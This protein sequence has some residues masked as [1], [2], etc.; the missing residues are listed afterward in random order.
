MTLSLGAIL[1]FTELRNPRSS[2]VLA[3]WQYTLI[4]VSY[5]LSII[6]A[7]GLRYP[8]AI[9]PLAYAQ[10]ILDTLI[11]S[12]LVTMTG[13]IESVFTFVYV[14]TVLGG[15]MTLYRRGAVVAV[16]AYFVSLGGIV[17]LQ[18]GKQLPV[19]ITF[20]FGRAMVSFS[21][22]SVGMALVAVLSS[23]LAEK[24]R[25]AGR[26]LAEKQID[27]EQLEELHAAILRSLP[28]GLMTIDGE[29]RVRYANEAAIAILRL[30]M[31]GAIGR[32]LAEVVAPMA[33]QWSEHRPRVSL[34]FDAA[35]ERF[36]SSFTRGD[37]KTIRIG[38]SFAP[39]GGEPGLGS[40]AVFQDVTEIVRLK[41]AVERAERLAT[42]GRL[43]AGLAHEVRNPLASM[44]ASIEVLRQ[45][46]N[47]PDP[48]KRLMS[49]VVKEADRLN[50]LIT[51]FLAFAR[52]REPERRRTDL[53][54][55]VAGVV[56]VL[57]HD[58]LFQPCKL[59]LALE[60]GLFAA[61]DADQIRQVVWN[62]A[63]N[64]AE[65]MRT[66]SNAVLS[67]QTK[68]RGDRVELIV[69]DTGPGIATEDLPRLFVPFYTT[70]EGGSGLG[71]AITHAIVEAHG[72]R[73]LFESKPGVG[74]EVTV[75]LPADVV[76]LPLPPP[77]R[78][79]AGNTIEPQL[80]PGRPA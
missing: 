37:G 67:I 53:S 10:I 52:P 35:R 12:V 5:G 33:K 22:Y 48:M 34:P 73:V 41:D 23:T 1:V 47:P 55:V 4:G 29:G 45:T 71:L 64:A 2:D 62:V 30:E 31:P 7:V 65:A 58:Q 42:V 49:N 9:M 14:F 18:V 27:Y 24:V 57:H 77:E 16:F 43:A 75:S 36:E 15:S 54:T 66:S 70:K 68:R 60:P 63:K 8:R 40:I 51:D 21:M 20:D 76:A 6:Y 13:G 28:A 11:G 59:E 79:Q 39:L 17:L 80:A 50:G 26:R 25:I 46:L 61:I 32:P 74:T 72:G 78:A 19:F 69:R 44:C 56:E 3:D 38:F